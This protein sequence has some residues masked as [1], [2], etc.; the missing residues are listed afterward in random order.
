MTSHKDKIK[1]T[2]T[3]QVLI[4]KWIKILHSN[5]IDFG[6]FKQTTPKSL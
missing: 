1:V 5:F 3:T 2:A 6:S 4:T